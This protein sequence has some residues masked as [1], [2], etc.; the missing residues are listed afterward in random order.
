MNF[1]KDQ[2]Y[3]SLEKKIYEQN[4]LIEKMNEENSALIKRQKTLEQSLK[5]I[6]S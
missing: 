1:R 3:S 5:V 2:A 4:D 6:F